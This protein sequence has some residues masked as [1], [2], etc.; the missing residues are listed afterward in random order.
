MKITGS[1]F[2]ERLRHFLAT[3]L[4]G[5]PM[6]AFLPALTL[7]TFWLGGETALLAVALGLPV[8]IAAAG[9][10]SKRGSSVPRDAV[11][12]MMLRDGF[13]HETARLY[14]DCAEA[15]LRSA[16]FVLELDEYK[17]LTDRHGQE[18]GDRIMQ[19]CGA[20]IVSALRQNDTIARISDNRFAICLAPTLQLDLEL[21]IQL[22]GRM[23]AAAEEPLALDGTTVYMTASIGFCQRS[24]APGSSS[25]E[26]IS[27]A[28]S[29]LS[30]AH[31]NGPGGI[32]AYSSDMPARGSSRASLREEAAAA[33]E[34]GQIQAWFQPQICTDTGRVSG[35]EAL[36]RWLHP[37][38]GLIPPSTFLPA[39]EEA[40]LMDRLSQ[41]MLYNALVAIKAWDEAGVTVPCVGVNFATQELRNP[42]LA[43]R[44]KW[45]LERFGLP[46][47]RLCVEIL[48]TVMTD[49]P[50]DV[51]TR[52]ILALSELG[53]PIDLDDFGTG[54][55]SIS[56]VRRFNISRIKIDRTF[57]M[58]ADQDPEQQ[59]LISAILTMAE[60]L[61]LDTLAEGVETA[62]EHALLAQLGCGHVQGF[63]I[64]RPMPF[65][66][67]LDWITAHEAKLQDAPVI[68]RQTP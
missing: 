6:L 4:V 10:F 40:G 7:A 52:N 53:C 59:K 45:E 12:G 35:F 30:E 58:K 23:Q 49:Q 39:L 63:G 47:D 15:G 62:G 36:A 20:Q 14:H 34:T 18:A 66:Q 21:C 37:V 41:V 31:G 27:A 33:L 54:H 60:R 8:L 24:R 3:A 57:V 2:L 68:G 19:H 55:A 43:G 17:E 5:P 65:D 25:A 51:V 28:V 61:D 48:E 9:G 26:W 22:A 56:A 32:R 50:D 13:E 46:A 1:G 16:V 44:V 11:T 29:A 42:G 64:G 38:Q 67:T